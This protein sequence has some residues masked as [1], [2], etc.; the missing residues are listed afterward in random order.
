MKKGIKMKLFDSHA[1]YNDEKFDIDRES[2]IEAT[3][4]EVEKVVIV[5]I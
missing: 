1:H 3:R 2:I 4:K 5:R